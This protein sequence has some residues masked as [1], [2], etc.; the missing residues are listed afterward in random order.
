MSTYS[1][2]SIKI[3]QIYSFL[4]LFRNK[5]YRC[6]ILPPNKLISVTK[7]S[8]HSMFFFHRI[9]VEIIILLRMSSLLRH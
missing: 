1:C 4:K 2:V 8:T 3:N 5:H 6:E 7:V 9:F